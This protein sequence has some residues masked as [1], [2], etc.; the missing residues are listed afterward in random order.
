MPLGGGPGAGCVV[1]AGGSGWPCCL[2]GWLWWP[3]GLSCCPVGGQWCHHGWPHH[4][5]GWPWCH[6][7]PTS[8]PPQP[9]YPPHYP[10]A[11]V[12]PCHPFAPPP[13]HT[14][15]S[16]AGH[17]PSPRPHPHGG[18]LTAWPRGPKKSDF[19]FVLFLS[20]VTKHGSPWVLREGRGASA[21]HPAP[22]PPVP[23]QGAG[24]LFRIRL[25]GGTG[26]CAYLSPQDPRP[27]CH[28]AVDR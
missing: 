27:L 15:T 8:E 19:I 22:Q 17:P 1:D 3:Y 28:P 23:S 12:S 5:H 4:R 14:T 25:A 10:G 11:L 13:G 20:P 16:G 7:A 9:N 21:P 2:C 26:P 24:A 6:P 18:P